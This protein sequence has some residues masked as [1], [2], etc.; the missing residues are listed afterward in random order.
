[1]TWNEKVACE[2]T[3]DEK[4]DKYN[5]AKQQQPEQ[6][7]TLCRLYFFLCMWVDRRAR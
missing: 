3:N 5:Q 4:Q 6:G 7:R 2:I 1:M